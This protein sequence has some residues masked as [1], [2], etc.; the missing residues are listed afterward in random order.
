[1]ISGFAL[2]AIPS[3]LDEDALMTFGMDSMDAMPPNPIG[4]IPG[5]PQK[6]VGQVP[7]DVLMDPRNSLNMLPSTADIQKVLSQYGFGQAP[8]QAWRVHLL[9]IDPEKAA[10]RLRAASTLEDLE[11]AKKLTSSKTAKDRGAAAAKLGGFSSCPSFCNQEGLVSSLAA[12]LDDNSPDVRVEA[13]ASLAL[14]DELA[15]PHLDKILKCL[16]DEDSVKLCST[17]LNAAVVLG[18]LGDSEPRKD[19]VSQEIVKLIGTCE[20]PRMKI[21]A[22]QALAVLNAK[23]QAGPIAD[24]LKSTNAE[25][26]A[27]AIQALGMIQSRPYD[28]ALMLSSESETMRAYACNSLG[29][30]LLVGSPYVGE[31]MSKLVDKEPLV[32]QE[33]VVALSQMGKGEYK[34][35]VCSALDKVLEW[36]DPSMHLFA[37]NALGELKDSTRASKITE[38]LN[39]Y[40]NE[41]RFAAIAVLASMQESPGPISRLLD[42]LD[43]DIRCEAVKA[44]GSMGEKSQKTLEKLQRMFDKKMDKAVRQEAIKAIA[45]IARTSSKREKE[46]L[47][48][49]MA[50]MLDKKADNASKALAIQCLGVLSAA[51]YVEKIADQCQSTHPAEL[52]IAGVWALARIK[53]DPE[54]QMQILKKM[55]EEEDG[56]IRGEVLVQ[57]SYVKEHHAA[58]K[59]IC[60]DLLNSKDREARVSALYALAGLQI[61]KAENAATIAKLLNDP[62]IDIIYGALLGLSTIGKDASTQGPA[63]AK[64]LSHDKLDLQ[65]AAVAT[66]GAVQ[67]KQCAK[68]VA[69]K[70]K[71]K[72]AGV[73]DKLPFSEVSQKLK[74]IDNMKCAAA[75]ALGKMEE[76]GSAH[77]DL[78]S[79]LIGYPLNAVR[80]SACMALSCLAESGQSLPSGVVEKLRT[81]AAS[82]EFVWVREAAAGAI[83]HVNCNSYDF[84]WD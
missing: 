73:S 6:L 67:A 74:E 84:S 72:Q 57:C 21:M 31:V 2:P 4:V 44:L 36:D 79:E 27:T 42:D 28:V 69:E 77:A 1:M 29:N 58:L 59:L 14:M 52:R 41:V 49:T 30:M 71:V 51:K 46:N 8:S 9:D 16:S 53:E 55:T 63:I 70:L 13:C 66:L 54:K 64:L 5:L 40:S 65:I 22:M 24:M 3:A 81:T 26:V 25:I 38:F 34:E 62:D 48:D 50:S 78:I 56:G 61:D 12:L 15:I 39:S 76:A 20:D 7:K 23:K 18:A 11:S 17:A 33:A 47:A 10:F 82:D 75:L 83:N 68:E 35:V 60:S 80:Q 37:V 32:Q 19:K 45:M 43:S